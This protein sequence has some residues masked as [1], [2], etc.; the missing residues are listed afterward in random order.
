MRVVGDAGE[1]LIA[2]IIAGNHGVAI[3]AAVGGDIAEDHALRIGDVSLG[4]DQLRQCKRTWCSA[5]TGHIL[6]EV[7]LDRLFKGSL[8]DHI[9]RPKAQQADHG[10]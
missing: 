10:K 1:D 4:L 5:E 6:G 8:G 2:V 9:G 7:S 3:V